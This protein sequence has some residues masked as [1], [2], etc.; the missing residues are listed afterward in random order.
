MA[1]TFS[2]YN[3]TLRR[4]LAKEVS[5]TDLKVMLLTDDAVFDATD[6]S[7]DEVAGALSGSP[8]ERANEAYGNG[9]AQGGEILTTVSV[10]TVST[11]SARVSADNVSVVA[12]G[13]PIPSVAAYKAV[14]YDDADADKAPLLFITFDSPRQAGEGT[15]F[16]IS[17]NASGI[18]QV[19][20]A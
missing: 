3:S 8:S 2:K 16:L 18:I 13:G 1:D 15:N 17:W 9:W 11:S 10:S 5:L 14:I 19:Q 4:L 6:T 12:S 7:L 20:W